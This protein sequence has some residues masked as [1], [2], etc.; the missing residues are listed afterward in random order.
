[1]SPQITALFLLCILLFLQGS[2]AIQSRNRSRSAFLHIFH[3]SFFLWILSQFVLLLLANHSWVPSVFLTGTNV[4]S[5]LS[6]PMAIWSFYVVFHHLQGSTPDGPLWGLLGLLCVVLAT[7]N[8]VFA[9]EEALFTVPPAY[10]QI[11]FAALL[12]P[13]LLVLFRNLSFVPEER[14]LNNEA[15]EFSA[16][17][18]FFFVGGTILH[19][20]SLFQFPTQL[21]STGA[22]ALGSIVL[23]HGYAQFIQS[24]RKHLKA[25]AFGIVFSV[26]GGLIWYA[27]AHITGMHE[28]SSLY[29]IHLSLFLLLFY[30]VT[31]WMFQ[32]EKNQLFDLQQ[33]AF[34][35]IS[36]TLTTRLNSITSSLE[37]ISDLLERN[38]KDFSEPDTEFIPAG[39][40]GNPFEQPQTAPSS[41]S[42]QLTYYLREIRAQTRKLKKLVH[43][44][45]FLTETSDLQNEP[46]AVEQAIQHCSNEIRSIDKWSDIEFVLHCPA[47]IPNV[48]GSERGLQRALL[49][50]MSNAAES[51]QKSKHVDTPEIFINVEKRNRILSDTV[52]ISITDGGQPLPEEDLNT[53]ISPFYTTKENHLGLGLTVVER[54][55]A[56]MNS[57]LNVEMDEEHQRRKTFYV[58]LPV[59][60]SDQ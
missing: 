13:F 22:F 8:I 36:S 10:I 53:L 29:S 50:L 42:D 35:R 58:D 51:I 12:F 4:L 3:W 17:I 9:L 1:M 44:M 33:V 20:F 28:A 54:I 39:S 18:A 6:G 14:T 30:G 5:S 34:E 43:G 11:G 38:I 48:Q 45:D 15:Q 40:E 31:I 27:Y 25:S 59:A 16:T 56:A 47:S 41:D 26:A 23:H 49:E 57:R 37:V 19:L 21:A 24:P 52:R 2:S 7:T 46:V 55:I 32:P 60:E